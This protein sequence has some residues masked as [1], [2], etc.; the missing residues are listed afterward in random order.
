MLYFSSVQLLQ[1]VRHH[2]INTTF[3]QIKIFQSTI[4]FYHLLEFPYV[5]VFS[6]NR[7]LDQSDLLS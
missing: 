1:S 4:A 5:G 7:T 3:R 6:L 2:F